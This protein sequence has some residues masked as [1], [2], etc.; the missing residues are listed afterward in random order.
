MDKGLMQRIPETKSPTDDASPRSPRVRPDDVDLIIV[1]RDGA[2][3][4]VTWRELETRANQIARA[5]QAHRCTQAN[6]V[7]GTRT[8]ELRRA[9][10]RDR[11]HLEARRNPAAA[12][13]RPARLGDGAHARAA[14]IRRCWS[15]TSTTRAPRDVRCSPAPTLRR[16]ARSPTSRSRT[17]CRRSSTWSRR[18]AR[19]AS[20]SSSSRP[21][22]GVLEDEPQQGS[23]K[24]DVPMVGPGHVAALPR[25]R[26]RL[27]VTDDARRRSCRAHGEVRRRA[28]PSSSSRSTRSRSP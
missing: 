6:D 25:E 21:P 4:E 22:R 17:R 12:P 19:P 1:D 8:A 9:R 5:L 24:G 15:A 27:R 16:R 2:E 13:T 3:R 20:R 14:P 18:R 23:T 28:R 11:G 26:V 7:V 10:V